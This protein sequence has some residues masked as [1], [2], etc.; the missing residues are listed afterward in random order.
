[1]LPKYWFSKKGKARCQFHQ[2]FI[3]AVF[4]YECD[5]LY[6]LAKID[7]KVDLNF[8]GNSTPGVNPTKL[9]SLQANIFF[10]FKLDH[11]IAMALFS[12]NTKVRKINSKNLKIKKNEVW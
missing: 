4:F 8:F 1:M 11:F 7:V 12:Y 6:F 2:L 9:V 10:S 5:F 3:R